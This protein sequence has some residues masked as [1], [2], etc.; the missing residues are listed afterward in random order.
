MSR[1]QALLAPLFAA[2]G[3]VSLWL[4]LGLVAVTADSTAARLVALAPFW[5]LAVLIAAALALVLRFKPSPRQLSPLLLTLLIWL[6]FL[7]GPV[8]PA[9][10]IWQ[11]PIEIAVW[12]LV[13]VA[14]AAPAVSLPGSARAPLVAAILAAGAYALGAVALRDQLPIGDEP[15]YMVITQ[16]LLKDGDLRIENQ[17]RNRDYLA[18][19]ASDIQPHYIRRGKDGQIYSVHGIGV[20]VLALPAF[21]LF[22]YHGAVATVILVVAGASAIGWH[23]AWL[24]TGDV[25]A[26]WLAWAAI[27]LTAP[28]YQQAIT[29]FPDAV[30]CLGVIAGVWLLVALDAR[31]DVRIEALLWCGA[32]LATLPWLHTRFALLVAGLGIAAAIR[33]AQQH[34]MRAVLFL[35]LPAVSTVAWLAFFWW[36]WGTPDPRA[37][38]GIAVPGAGAEF[39][40]RGLTGLLLDQRAGIL[41]TAPVYF[42][43]FIGWVLMAR[44]RLRL[45]I[46]TVM[47]A[48]VLAASVATYDAWW[49]GYGA[50]G[51][52][53]VA[54][55][56]VAIVPIA[57]LAASR[58]WL[59]RPI[60]VNATVMS[61]FLLVARLSLAGGTYAY[62]PEVGVNPVVEQLSPNVD[63]TRV[64]PVSGRP[65]AQHY[66]AEPASPAWR[67]A[68][69][70][71]VA[72]VLLFAF[73]PLARRVAGGSS[74]APYVFVAAAAAIVVMVSASTMWAANGV[75]GLEPLASQ[76]RLVTVW[77]PSWHRLSGS[78]SLRLSASADAASGA[79]ATATLGDVRV[80]FMDGHA[81]P[82]PT[83]F[84]VQAEHDT[85]VVMQ[86]DDRTRN[87]GLRLQAGPVPTSAD[88]RVNGEW[89]HVTFRERERH[90]MAIPP[91]PAGAWT[92]TIR[93]GP[94]FRPQDRDPRVRDARILGIWVEVF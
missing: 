87:L 41:A 17:H 19:Y 81:Y 80:F 4:T 64:V 67:R 86:M 56:P 22:G 68:G 69:V 85:T 46:E 91:S 42:G 58:A 74:S 59:S 3:A 8:P 27:F 10:L 89:R 15:H 54:M 31:R 43:A 35:A 49:G 30:G 61:L 73:A 37:P 52:Y 11:G 66:V 90:E 82:E 36:I 70:W 26:A 29:V 94:G 48:I 21:A 44:S 55:L 40:A 24:L 38:W 77:Q 72:A 53:I 20:S 75:S 33:L 18:Y 12:L 92:I 79:R 34:V 14:M 57:W 88:V 63:L 16:S 62:V 28:I 47:I 93:P 50:P 2:I 32:A 71:A 83:G 78:G 13:L 84:W 39:I 60:V 6:P 51:R 1:A 45:A 9:F 65:E 25:V 5:L 76:L 23:A 7:P